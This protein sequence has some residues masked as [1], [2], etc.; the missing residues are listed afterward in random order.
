MEEE[1]EEEEEE[2]GRPDCWSGIGSSCLMGLL[3]NGDD[4]EVGDRSADY[5]FR[6]GFGVRTQDRSRS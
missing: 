4:L 1:E 3:D 2:E 6:G 5:G